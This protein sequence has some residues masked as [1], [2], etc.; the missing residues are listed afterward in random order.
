MKKSELL[1]RFDHVKK[2]LKDDVQNQ[3][4]YITEGFFDALR[5]ESRNLLAVAV[6]GSSLA[7][8][9]IKILEDEI[10]EKR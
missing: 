1:Y 2:N 9:Q 6:L 10:G 7:N 5:L 3:Q 4:I 8:N